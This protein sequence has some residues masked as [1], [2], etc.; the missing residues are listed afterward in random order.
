[1]TKVTSSPKAAQMI[2]SKNNLEKFGGAEKV[3]E[4]FLVDVGLSVVDELQDGLQ[5]IGVGLPQHDDRV[6]CRVA[7]EHLL[8]VGA[9]DRL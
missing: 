2:W 7:H 6:G 9:G 1:M 3:V 5:L 4:L 8:E